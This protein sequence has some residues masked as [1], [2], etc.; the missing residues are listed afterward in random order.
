M[1]FADL[2]LTGAYPIQLQVADINGNKNRYFCRYIGCVKQSSILVSHLITGR[3]NI[4]LDRDQTLQARLMIGRGVCIF[5]AKIIDLLHQPE[6]MML[7]TYPKKVEF[8]QIRN[9]ERVLTSQKVIVNNAKEK[10]KVSEGKLSDVSITG[11][12]LE[13]YR[14][15]AD[16]GEEVTISGDYPIETISQ[17]MR[18][19][20]VIRTR[21][22]PSQ[23]NTSIHQPI[24]YGVEFLNIPDE[25]KLILFGYVNHLLALTHLPQFDL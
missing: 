5:P 8:K 14:S 15:I 18:I 24:T 25:K 9:A 1:E 3:K 2:H 20:A 16:V 17:T 23:D 6:S 22:L 21:V 19:K 7:L 13:M 12:R 4:D 10:D 11:A